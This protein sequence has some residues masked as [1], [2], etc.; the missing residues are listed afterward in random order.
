[1]PPSP[2]PRDSRPRLGRGMGDPAPRRALD[3]DLLLG[4]KPSPNP[5]EPT[6]SQGTESRKASRWDGGIMGPR[7]GRA[8]GGRGDF[9]LN[10]SK[11]VAGRWGSPAGGEKWIPLPLSY[12][13]RARIL[14]WVPCP[15][16]KASLHSPSGDKEGEAAW[17]WSAV[18]SVIQRLKIKT[19]SCCSLGPHLISPPTDLCFLLPSW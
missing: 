10:L 17:P 5:P 8:R 16:G 18:R 6:P 1:M 2:P 4:D 12:R 7:G 3:R 11:M 9:G 15:L 13:T 19:G 14:S